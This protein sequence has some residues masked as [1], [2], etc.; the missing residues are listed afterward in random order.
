MFQGICRCITNTTIIII[1]IT[2]VKANLKL[3]PRK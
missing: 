2:I 1:I 3:C